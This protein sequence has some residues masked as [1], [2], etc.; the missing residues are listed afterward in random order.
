MMKVINCMHVGEMF[1]E[2]SL[3]SDAGK[4]LKDIIRESYLDD[5]FDSKWQ[6]AKIQLIRSKSLQSVYDGLYACAMHR[7]CVL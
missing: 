4:E 3:T 1:E 7:L 2:L 5:E 6:P